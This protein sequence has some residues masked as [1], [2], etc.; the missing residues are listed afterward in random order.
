MPLYALSL[1]LSVSVN[2]YL[3][4]LFFCTYSKGL[5]IFL[6]M[7]LDVCVS[8][9]FCLWIISGSILLSLYLFDSSYIYFCIFLSLHLSEPF[10][11]CVLMFM[12][13]IYMYVSVCFCM[14]LYLFVSSS[15][16]FC[17]FLSLH[18]S[19]YHCIFLPLYISVLSWTINCILGWVNF[20]EFE[21]TV[22]G[23]CKMSQ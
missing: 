7:Y 18:H 13:S 16:Y 22:C 19:T 20:S 4:I 6:Y 17:I 11:L 10:G 9:C 8:V 14:F 23:S 5:F 2:L 21:I 15:I 1:Y 12:Y 3:C